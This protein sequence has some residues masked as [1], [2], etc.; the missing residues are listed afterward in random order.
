[1]EEESE[2]THVSR[3]ARGSLGDQGS[4]SKGD[5]VWTSGNAECRPCVRDGLCLEA[6]GCLLRAVPGPHRKDCNDTKETGG[7]L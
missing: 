3:V 7:L 2:C 4:P 6:G 5:H 1:M